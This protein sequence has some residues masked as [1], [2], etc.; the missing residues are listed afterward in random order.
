[1]TASL[2]HN[3]TPHF[4]ELRAFGDSRALQRSAIF[5]RVEVELCRLLDAVVTYPAPPSHPVSERRSYR[6][7]AWNIERGMNL[8]AIL[9]VLADH[10]ELKGADVYFLT[11][12]DFGMARSANRDVAGE[13]AA[14]LGVGGVFVPCYLNLDKGSGLEQH[15]GG[16]NLY[17][18]HGNA[19]FS[20]WPIEDAA[21]VRLPNGKDK[22][23][24][25]EK[26]LGSQRVA[27]GTVK[28]PGGALRCASL[29]LDAHSSQR[30]RRGQMR[31]ILDALDAF[32]IPALLG[33]D[34]NTS[35]HNTSRALWS[36]IGFCV[37]VGMGV[38]RCLRDHYPHPD[39]LFERGLFRMLEGRGYDYRELNQNGA[40][41]FEHRILD[42]KDRS[43]LLDW[44]PRW[45]L[46]CIEWGLRPHDGVCAM[47]LDWF[48]GRGLR[49]ASDSPPRVVKDASAD[50][51]RLSDHD[52]II[53]NFDYSP[54]Q[55]KHV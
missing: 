5:R 33:G 14:R 16:D 7:V 31:A 40:C 32:A 27:L 45:C 2:A 6:A 21:A 25:R 20:P 34:W 47:K 19:L 46:D 17:G 28:L 55:V 41:T 36:I 51:R 4:G 35:T 11:E 23:R 49:P 13:I 29:H 42:E 50:T 52:P 43:N 38:G 22:M 15:A 48:A 18:L 1:M 10:P 9:A 54:E 53:L 12:L 26:R 3:L 24:G 39:R 37:R 30:H 8:D 44:V